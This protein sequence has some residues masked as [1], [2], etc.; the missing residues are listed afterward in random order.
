MRNPFIKEKWEQKAHHE[1]NK[2][3]ERREMKICRKIQR[4]A[5][6]NPEMKDVIDSFNPINDAIR[7]ARSVMRLERINSRSGVS[8]SEIESADF[9]RRTS[10]NSLIDTLNIVSR[11]CDKLDLDTSWREEI[12][13][14]RDAI[15]RWAMI[16][17]KE[18]QKELQEEVLA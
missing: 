9:E 1:T 18:K 13:Q 11:M 12:G 10:H 15:G 2:E 17:A 7:Y 5:E 6:K 14:T 4:I 8:N 16:V 3:K